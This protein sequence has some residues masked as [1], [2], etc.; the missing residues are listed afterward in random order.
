MT[1]LYDATPLLMRSAGV[2]NYH[3]ALL[4]RLIPSI[5]PHRLSLFPYLKSL[6][7]NQNQR[8]N[9]PP[10]DTALR[11]GGILASNYLR[12]PMVGLAARGA[13]LFHLTPHV[14]RLPRKICLSAMI[15][16][17]TPSL[18]PEFHTASNVRYFEHFVE[19]TMPRLHGILVPSQAVKEDLIERFHVNDD[20]IMVVHH[21][22]DEDY[23]EA[24]TPA[25]QNLLRHSYRV[26]NSYILFVGSIEPRKNLVRLV[27]AFHSLPED[28]QRSYPLVIAGGQ[29]WKNAEV[30]R[31]LSSA[32]HVLVVGHV[33]R[34]LMPALYQ[35]ASLFV[36]PSLYEGFGLP[37]LEAMAAGL[38][39]VAS[40][41]SAIPEV[42]GDTALLVDPESEEKLASTIRQMLESPHEM[43]S[44]GD[45]ARQRARQFS[46]ERAAAATKKFF[47]LSL[48]KAGA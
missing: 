6:A 32:R 2:K 23:F 16:D 24:S 43:R 45:A 42:A 28:V 29:G 35:G 37:L 40:N 46:W 21:G 48:G 5:A 15:H 38:P 9:Y 17:P 26:P 39:I 19:H 30:Q 22:V 8:S 11:L 31:R 34:K 1:I 25:A 12:F 36:F 14:R 4:R 7:V 18:M 10:L 20:R 41:R 33:R 27:K 47:E 3:H 44:L 13:D